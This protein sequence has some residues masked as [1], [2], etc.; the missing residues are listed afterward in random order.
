MRKRFNGKMLLSYMLSE[1]DSSSLRSTVLEIV[2]F[3]LVL[4][5]IGTV[6]LFAGFMPT[7]GFSLKN[8]YYSIFHSISAFCN[9]GFSLYDSGLETFRLN[10]LIL[11]TITFLVVFSGIG[12]SVLRELRLFFKERMR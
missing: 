5:A 8:I 6:L 9:A 4:E 2:A 12:F 1:D 3:T 11:L 10:P 7:L